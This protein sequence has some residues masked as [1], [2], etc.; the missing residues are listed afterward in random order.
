MHTLRRK[1]PHKR[2]TKL[3]VDLKVKNI[4]GTE[5]RKEQT[6]RFHLVHYVFKYKIVV[7]FLLVLRRWL[8][9]KLYQS[10]NGKV[11][12]EYVQLWEEAFSEATAHWVHKY[13]RNASG[14]N[15]SYSLNDC[16]E[17]V[18]K[19]KDFSVELLNTIKKSGSVLFMNDDAYLEWLPFFFVE[20]HRLMDLKFKEKGKNGIAT[21]LLHTVNGEMNSVYEMVYLKLR[22][23]DDLGIEIAGRQKTKGG[24]S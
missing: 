11:Q 14:V 19:N 5:S 7:P 12:F 24:R 18:L 21:H 9:K 1:N 8:D 23:I 2:E 13:L 16:R 6:R 22:A 20:V 15:K 3:K 17:H 4:Y 10:P